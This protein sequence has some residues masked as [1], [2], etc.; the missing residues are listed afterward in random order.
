MTYLAILPHDG[1]PALP[2][3]QPE[4]HHPEHG[5]Q[6]PHHEQGVHVPH[7]PLLGQVPDGIRPRLPARSLSV[8]DIVPHADMVALVV[9]DEGDVAGGEAEDGEG[10][11][12]G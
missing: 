7:R 12:C 2:H 4:I 8:A 6:E 10:E 3:T 5:T 11:G 1:Q 9:G